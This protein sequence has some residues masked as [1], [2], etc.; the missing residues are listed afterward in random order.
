LLDSITDR[1]AKELKLS[2]EEIAGLSRSELDRYIQ[3][4]FGFNPDGRRSKASMIN[5]FLETKGVKE[6]DFLKSEESEAYK[7]RQE[8]LQ[9]VRDEAKE[10]VGNMSKDDL[11]KEALKL[12]KMT[13]KELDEYVE[14]EYGIMLDARKSKDAMARQFNSIVKEWMK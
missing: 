12:K 4:N 6:E 5:Q 2:K 8:E 9:S 10:R 3:K 14:L 1:A 11:R 7:K 13:K